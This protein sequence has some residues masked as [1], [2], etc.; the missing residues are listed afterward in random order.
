MIE[1]SFAE[2]FATEWI[3][4]WNS[5]DLER[6]LSHY[7][8]DFEMNSP[9]IIQMTS[10]LSGRLKGKTAVGAYWAKALQLIPDLHFELISTL[11]G[12]DSITLY[13][14]GARGRLAAEVFHFGTD[15]KVVQA[16]AHYV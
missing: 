8:D 4:A 16:F 9:I 7:A 6:V 12:V 2:H 1:N 14:R 3:E 10:E 13:Y 15:G 11:V 5:H